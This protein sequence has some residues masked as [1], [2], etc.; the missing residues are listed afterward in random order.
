M[1]HFFDVKITE[2]LSAIA[3]TGTFVIAYLAYRRKKSGPK[4]NVDHD[5]TRITFSSSASVIISFLAL[6]AASISLSMYSPAVF[7]KFEIIFIVFDSLIFGMCFLLTLVNLIDW[8]RD[9]R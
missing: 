9:R 8:W 7:G 2:I 6:L 3:S 1:N 4:R 5:A